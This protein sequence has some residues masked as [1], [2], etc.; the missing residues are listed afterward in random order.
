MRFATDYRS[1]SLCA[2]STVLLT[3]Q[4]DIRS[5]PLKSLSTDPA[6]SKKTFSQMTPEEN[7]SRLMPPPAGFLDISS[8]GEVERLD[9]D[10]FLANFTLPA[11]VSE[12]LFKKYLSDS[13]T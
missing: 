6:L 10:K 4:Q 5:D 12:T 13:R 11:N 7:V 1:F 2:C 8:S 9:V 3:S